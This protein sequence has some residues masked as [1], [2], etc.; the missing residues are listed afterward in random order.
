M[1]R[2]AARRQRLM[3]RVKKESRFRHRKKAKAAWERSRESRAA[4][5]GE[6]CVHL[7]RTLRLTRTRTFPPLSPACPSQRHPRNTPRTCRS[8]WATTS[9]SWATSR[10]AHRGSRPRS[11][12]WTSRTACTASQGPRRA[13]RSLWGSRSSGSSPRPGGAPRHARPMPRSSRRSKHGPRR[14]S[15]QCRTASASTIRRSCRSYDCVE[16]PTSSGARSSRASANSPRS[17]RRRRPRAPRRISVNASERGQ[18]AR[19]RRL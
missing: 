12:A 15:G 19:A 16:T 9:R 5:R 11:Y 4:S 3:P 17:G 10:S 7:N 18:S 14:S 6:L 1:G 2:K 13:A 8:A